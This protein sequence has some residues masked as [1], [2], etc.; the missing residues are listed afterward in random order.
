METGIGTVALAGESPRVATWIGL[1]PVCE[2]IAVANASDVRRARAAKTA[3][4][5]RPL[6][7]TSVSGEGS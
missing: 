5:A 4:T 6:E 7:A 2:G 1:I 3:R